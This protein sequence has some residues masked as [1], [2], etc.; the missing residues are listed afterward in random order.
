M[1]AACLAGPSGT[2]VSDE[3][4]HGTAVRNSE[5]VVSSGWDTDRLDLDAYLARIG[6]NRE[7]DPSASTLTALHRAHLAAVPFENLDIVLGRGIAV[8]FASVQDKLV[9]RRRGGYCFEHGI[10]FAAALERLGYSVD[11]LLARVGGDEQRPRPRSHM[12]L[13][14]RANAGQWLA[15]VGFGDGLLEPLPWDDTRAA[16]RQGGWTYQLVSAG[17]S[18]WQ[19]RERLGQEW[20]VRYRFTEE[21]QHA[22]DVTVANHFTSTHPSSR[23]VG[24]VVVVRKDADAARRLVGR[25]LTTARPD[26]SSD[27]RMLTDAEVADA[28]A[29][30]FGVPLSRAEAGNVIAALPPHEGQVRL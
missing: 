26:G 30:D 3:T 17:G 28:L 1:R 7:L 22:S 2:A 24:Q 16:H 29:D 4:L 21:P 10:L 27:E 12:T 11:R 18:S 13:R 5:P 8:D 9:R 6:H 19:L 15:D 20:T 23:F 25:R 14:V